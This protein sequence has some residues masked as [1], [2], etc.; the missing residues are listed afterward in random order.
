MYIVNTTNI[1]KPAQEKLYFE[2][3]PDCIYLYMLL[4]TQTTIC[5]SFQGTIQESEELSSPITES[6]AT[7]E[8]DFKYANSLCY[9]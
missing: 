4:T 3:Y 9:I 7:G 5:Q 8:C 2:A 1:A 6:A